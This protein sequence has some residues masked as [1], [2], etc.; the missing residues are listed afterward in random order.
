MPQTVNFNFALDGAP[1]VIKA[2]PC[3]FNSDLQYK[4]SI[5]GGDEVL[6]TFDANLGRYAPVGDDAIDITDSL[7]IAI[8]TKLNGHSLEKQ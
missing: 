2:A 3:Y 6:F 8:G 7:E 1:Y 4:V 5:N